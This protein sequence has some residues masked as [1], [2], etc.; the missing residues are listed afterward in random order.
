MPL[1]YLKVVML[2]S[3]LSAFKIGN[4]GKFSFSVSLRQVDSYQ[5]DLVKK[6]CEG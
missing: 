3:M 2:R 4:M 1:H 6:K 5:K